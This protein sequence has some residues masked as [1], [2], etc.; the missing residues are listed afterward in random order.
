M[1]LCRGRAPLLHSAYF[2]EQGALIVSRAVCVKLVLATL[3][4]HYCRENLSFSVALYIPSHV[5]Q[6]IKTLVKL[7]PAKPL[8]WA[9]L[10]KHECGPLQ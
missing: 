3:C 5:W 2:L 8:L 9:G 10:Y 7:W 6:N 4:V 1:F